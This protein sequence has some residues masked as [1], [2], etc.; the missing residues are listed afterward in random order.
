M[1]G[2]IGRRDASAEREKAD[3][4][5]RCEAG[6]QGLVGRSEKPLPG[7]PELPLDLFLPADR[8]LHRMFEPGQ[9]HKLGKYVGRRC[10]S[11]PLEERPDRREIAGECALDQIR[12]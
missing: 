1:D 12:T 6:S 10:A 4:D 5:P 2:G 9:L 3:A 7:G 11:P 8:L